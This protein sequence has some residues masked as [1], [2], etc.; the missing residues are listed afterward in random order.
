M[1]LKKNAIP[2]V[3]YGTD[4]YDEHGY[5][6]IILAKGENGLNSLDS[7]LNKVKFTGTVSGARPMDQD[8]K[9][10]VW[11]YVRKYMNSKLKDTDY[12]G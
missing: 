12:F 11:D 2:G 3:D 6:S 9:E 8:T 7:M 5:E 10:K 4:W 1:Q